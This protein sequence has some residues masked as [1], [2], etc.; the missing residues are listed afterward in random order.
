VSSNE[1]VSFQDTAAIFDRLAERWD[2]EHG[3]ASARAEAFAAHIDYLSAHCVRLDRPRVLDIGCG[4]GQHLI[5]LHPWIGEGVGIDLS[6]RMIDRAAAN[7]LAC[8]SHS[9][10]FA[11]M[12]AEELTPEHFGKFDVVLFIG[13]LEHMPSP[14][15]MLRRARSVLQPEGRIVIVM[16][17]RFNLAHWTVRGYNRVPVRHLSLPALCALAAE[18]GLRLDQAA[19]LPHGKDLLRPFGAYGERLFA[20]RLVRAG[21][22]LRGAFGAS[23][24]HAG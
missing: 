11:Q 3:P 14:A 17:H 15:A 10:R 5:R 24:K 12:S 16:P 20:G 4:T 9:L 6:S 1:I 19:A 13:V 7:G 8:G 21:V 23:L 2:F 18:E 22:V